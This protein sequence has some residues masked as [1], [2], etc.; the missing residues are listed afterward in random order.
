V[1]RPDPLDAGA[2]W[3]LLPPG[4]GRVLASFRRAAYVELAGSVLA[5]TAADVPPGPLHL[6]F[7]ALPRLQVGD[8]VVATA[9]HLTIGTHT[10]ARRS[11]WAGGPRSSPVLRSPPGPAPGWTSCPRR[12]PPPSPATRPPPRCRTPY[13][14]ATFLPR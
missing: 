10:V 5:V 9:A 13:V 7:S 12:A 1:A 14:A 11:W 2:G 3:G 8:P 4:R 6:R